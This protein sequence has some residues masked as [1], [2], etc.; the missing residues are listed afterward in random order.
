MK[1]ETIIIVFL[2]IGIILS[3]TLY[4]KQTSENQIYEA[5]LS[6]N[7]F[8]SFAIINATARDT[9]WQ[10]KEIL[11]AGKITKK[12]ADRLHYYYTNITDEAWEIVE[13][14][15]HLRKIEN[16]EFHDIIFSN[17]AIFLYFL[18]MN[19]KGKFKK[20]D[21][22]MINGEQEDKLSQMYKQIKDYKIILKIFD[23]VNEGE[24][25]KERYYEDGVNKEYWLELLK[26]LK[27]VSVYK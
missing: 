10:L 8:N 27:S 9:E 24:A 21:T 1:K 7:L 5:H 20:E 11:D 25:Y 16:Q 3:T 2:I 26:Q 23:D 22:I 15:E 12:E 18:E 19:E 13:L 17:Q 14:G 6:M 4:V